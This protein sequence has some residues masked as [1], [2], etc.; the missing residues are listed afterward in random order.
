MQATLA[1]SHPTNGASVALIDRPDVGEA[2]AAIRRPVAVVNSVQ[3]PRAVLLD[4][5][6]Q[7]TPEILRQD[8]LAVLPPIYPEWLGERSFTA[9]H[10]VRF[11]YVVGEMARGIATPRMTVEGSARRGDGVLRQRRTGPGH[12]GGGCAGDSERPRSG[13]HRL[14]RQSDSQ[15]SERR[16]RIGDGR[17]VPSPRC[18]L[19]FSVG[20]HAP[21]SRGRPLRRKGA[22][23]AT[24]TDTSCGPDTFSPRFPATRSR[25]SS[26]HLLPKR[27]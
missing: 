1:N 22:C 19:R 11:P 7:L 6:G 5:V 2:L 15:R 16:H 25:G 17:S 3:G 13:F 26:S 10:G 18:P 8:L 24:R 23:A 9:T 20:V 27:C 14:G 4:G 21:D 12:C